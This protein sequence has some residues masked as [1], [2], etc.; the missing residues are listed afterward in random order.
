[1]GL[2]VFDPVTMQ[3]EHRKGD[4]VPAWFLDTDYNDKVFH[5]S[6]VFFPRTSAWDNLKRALKASYEETVWDHLAGTTSAPFEAGEHQQVAVK[7]IDDR[8]NELLV[9]KKL[10]K[11]ED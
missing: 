10:G 8:G 9:V 7:V 1:V 4:D 6:Q 5:V 11:V 2:D 3:T